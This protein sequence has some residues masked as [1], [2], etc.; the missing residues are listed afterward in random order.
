M[1]GRPEAGGS[2][3]PRPALGHLRDR[4]GAP[5]RLPEPVSEKM[6]ALQVRPTCLI[7]LSGLSIPGLSTAASVIA[8]Q[9]ADLQGGEFAREWE[10][11]ASQHTLSRESAADVVDPRPDPF[12]PLLSAPP[13]DPLQA[14]AMCRRVPGPC[15][16][17][18]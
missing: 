6:R 16:Q 4:R 15:L 8:A 12:N 13:G 11:S 1:R 14:L 5:Q 7:S 17:C 18:T 9:S 2:P 3:S 10:S